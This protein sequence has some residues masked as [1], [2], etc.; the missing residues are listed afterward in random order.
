MKLHNKIYIWS[1]VLEGFLF[2]IFIDRLAAGFSLSVAR[3]LQ[4]IWI[5]WRFAAP[6]QFIRG[7]WNVGR[8]RI[9][10]A[11]ILLGWT[12]F[13]LLGGYLSGGYVGSTTTTDTSTWLAEILSN[14][15]VRP[16]IE[17]LLFGYYFWYYV[18]V[19]GKILSQVENYS[20]LVRSYFLV[21]ALSMLIGFAD[22]IAYQLLGFGFVVRHLAE[23]F[24]ENPITPGDRFH[25]FGGE[26]RDAFLQLL[27]MLAILAAFRAGVGLKQS[28]IRHWVFVITFIA[29]MMTQ[30][31]S[32]LVGLPIF[33]V[34]FC[35]FYVPRNFGAST[36]LLMIMVIGVVAAVA[37]FSADYFFR[38]AY[39]TAV[40]ADIFDRLKEGSSG[41]SV[42]ELTQ[43]TNI[44]PL[45][46]FEQF[47][48]GDHLYRCVFG[49]GMSSSAYANTA[50]MAEGMA[51][52]HAEVT[53][54]LYE[55]GIGG[56]FI[57]CAFFV[58]MFTNPDR[59]RSRI[60]ISGQ[61]TNF[62]WGLVLLAAT[63]AHKSVNLWFY[64]IFV[65][66]TLNFLPAEI[67]RLRSDLLRNRWARMVMKIGQ[68]VVQRPGSGKGH[69]TEPLG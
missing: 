10:L 42:D 30:S 21:C 48:S 4:V 26:P 27:L 16:L 13:S 51:F 17:I 5:A 50:F 63:L 12:V 53:R 55:L 6:G 9:L 11:Y 65:I 37:A 68:N 14:L 52:P 58:S 61:R 67:E 60:G 22:L 8:R 24:Y 43:M 34:L 20:Y 45:F 41:L 64:C 32:G 25:G 29:L 62:L 40:Y 1:I 47:C 46:L 49:S 59:S 38:V 66:T 31:V 28:G 36:L 39:Y 7:S 3:A 33:A 15:A 57:Y 19:G 2:F 23:Y 44:Y 35:V 54:I 18:L 56:F 69:Q